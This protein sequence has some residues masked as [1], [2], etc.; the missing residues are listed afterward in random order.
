VLVLGGLALLIAAGG[1]A[2]GSWLWHRGQPRPEIHEAPEQSSAPEPEARPAPALEPQPQSE[3]A[4]THAAPA[5][6]P[7]AASQATKPATTIDS[8]SPPSEPRCAGTQERGRAAFE[9]REW[10]DVLTET[11]RKACWPKLEQERLALRTSA[12]FNLG[13]WA[14]CA[15]SG[16]TSS[17]PKVRSLAEACSVTAEREQSEP[18]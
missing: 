7:P 14:E 4:P 11:S 9:R 12:F 5:P 8:P 15:A 16:A 10:R 3:P 13:R 17:D 2:G 1:A 18:K 6:T